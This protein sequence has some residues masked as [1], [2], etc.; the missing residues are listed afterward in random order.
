MEDMSVYEEVIGRNIMENPLLT[1]SI[2]C[3]KCLLLV[4][5][6]IAQAPLPILIGYGTLEREAKPDPLLYSNTKMGYA[7]RTGKP[8]SCSRY[9]FRSRL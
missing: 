2:E 6:S 1:Q 3:P 9:A 5:S 7:P 8:S 4:C